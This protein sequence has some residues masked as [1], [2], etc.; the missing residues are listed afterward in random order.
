MNHQTTYTG[1]YVITQSTIDDTWKVKIT[2]TEQLV[3]SCPDQSSA[4]KVAHGLCALHREKQNTE[5]VRQ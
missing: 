3:A 1:K 4:I 5:G 2:E